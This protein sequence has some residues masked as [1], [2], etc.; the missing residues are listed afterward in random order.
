MEC[1]LRFHHAY[2]PPV[3]LEGGHRNHLDAVMGHFQFLGMYWNI[4][5]VLDTAS[6]WTSLTF[7]Q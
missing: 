5:L 7:G 3:L 1:C 2:R 4:G 6:E